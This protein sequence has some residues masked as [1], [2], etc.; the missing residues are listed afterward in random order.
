MPI[1]IVRKA[2]RASIPFSDPIMDLAD[3][4]SGKVRDAFLAAVVA[5]QSQIVLHELEAAISTGDYQR[6]LSIINIGDRFEKA[7]AGAGLPTNVLSVRDALRQVYAAAA[8]VAAKELPASIG[9]PLAFDLLN[10]ESV[11]FIQ[12]YGFNLIQQVSQSVRDAVRQVVD[13]AFR[14][15]GHPYVQAR[16]IRNFIGLTANQQAAV[17]NYRWA[18]ENGDRIALDRALRDRRFDPSVARAI[19]DSSRLPQWRIDQM[20]ERYRQR[21][22]LRRAQTVART[23]SLRASNMGQQTL[24]HQA[25]QQGLMSQQTKRRWH[26]GE[27]E[28][29]CPRCADLNGVEVGID[30]EFAPGIMN[31][32]DPH[33]S[34]RCN[35]YIVVSTM[36]RAA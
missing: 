14:E 4:M 17:A 32:P 6:V 16:E 19:R 36:K 7:M 33:P 20:V 22:L 24:W 26:T 8:G 27:D 13:R 9:T 28:R 3:R 18:L 25:V 2:S 11:A 34:C 23:E 29:V 12:N 35:Q 5:V 30:E 15:G 1:V 31:P 21:M 10:T